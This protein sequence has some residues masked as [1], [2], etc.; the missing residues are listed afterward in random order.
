MNSLP[1]TNNTAAY[2][3]L[4]ETLDPEL[5]MIKTFL[6]RYGVNGSVLP[7]VI[8]T[9]SR[10]NQGTGWGTVEIE[11]RNHQAIRVRGVFDNL[12][13]TFDDKPIKVDI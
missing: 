5:H 11:M 9:M 12:I 7:F 10:V 4:L 8:E 3:V 6:L 1:T 13:K 2:M